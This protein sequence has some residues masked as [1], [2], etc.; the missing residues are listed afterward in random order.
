ML[1]LKKAVLLSL[2]TM[3]VLSCIGIVI[4]GLI[5]KSYSKNRIADEL[6]NID[7][8]MEKTEFYYYD[9][10]DRYERRGEPKL[11]ND[12]ILDNGIKYEYASF[13]DIPQNLKNAFVAI[14]D[15]RFYKHNGID[16]MRSGKAILNYLL[17]RPRFG[18]S[19]IT[20]QL[21][22]NLT[23]HDEPTVN[24]KLNE[25]FFA[26]NLEKE[27]DKTEILETYM[28]V[29]N[30][31]DGCRGVKAAAEHFYS[32]EL[33]QLTLSECATIA[34]ITNNPSKYNPRTHPEENKKRRDIVLQC[35]LQQNMI[36]EKE[37]YQAI[38]EPIRL[39]VQPG[40]SKVNSWYIDTVCQDVINELCKK[41]QISPSA[42]SFMLYK[43][44][45]RIYT[46]MDPQIQDIMEKYY[47]NVYNF[48]IDENGDTA[49]SAMIIIDPYTGDILGTVGAIGEK[50]GNRVI[51]FATD[52]KRHPGSSLKPL[53]VYTPA[54]EKG[55][56]NWS[57]VI[58]DSPVIKGENGQS[59]WPLN[60]D[61]RYVGNVNVKYAIEHSLNTVAVKI[62][63]QIGANESIDFL[64]ESLGI[65]SLDK[66]RDKGDAALALGQPDYGI[67]LKELTA[68]YS[69]YQDGI[70]SK[71][72][73][74]YRVT[75]KNGVIIIDNASE[76]KAVISRE[77]AAIMTKLLETVVDTGT[78]SGKIKLDKKIDV[79]GKSGT[80][81][82]SF[83][84][85]FVGY[86]PEILGGVWFGY[87]Y[88]K[89]LEVF[90][91]N[92]SV[93][94]WDEVMS[95]IYEKTEYGRK[96]HFSVPDTVQKLTY[97]SAYSIESENGSEE[98]KQEGWFKVS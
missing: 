89:S 90:G 49:Q 91:G 5:L 81:G 98:L 12:A 29:I 92:L 40:N 60:V 93:Y 63:Q 47:S 34:A 57:T 73:S 74:F 4:C 2:I 82:N 51:N 94:I 78:A 23:G 42:A 30:L 3:S 86:T 37:C 24:R 66:K 80:S 1:K 20:Q 71:P 62:L 43:G 64:T 31:S 70:M 61:R 45:Y 27:Y 11:L 28:N 22:K 46:A 54:I 32:K 18:G 88:P 14:E 85:Y 53:S 16:V 25:A 56:I 35:M 48:P 67:T 8:N 38:S 76:Q 83:D 58:E 6:M 7:G 15:K 75:D 36:S 69:I 65:K 79:A 72:R 50:K 13:D 55:I 39:K 59:P 68:A 52:T 96:T 44:G 10:S 21:V 26:I 84:R 33:D 19:T 41:Y 77:T 9:F 87:E 95:E 97:D 17:G